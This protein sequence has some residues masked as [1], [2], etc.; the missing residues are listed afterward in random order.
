[1]GIPLGEYHADDPDAL[2][3]S[4][5][6]SAGEIFEL[7][8]DSYTAWIGGLTPHTA[9]QLR[10]WC[11]SHDVSGGADLIGELVRSGLLTELPGSGD[12]PTAWLGAY[13]I[14][15]QGAGIGNSTES[16]A[17]YT[18]VDPAGQPLLAVDAGLY[19]VWAMSASAASLTEAM[20]AVKTLTSL[21]P[22]ELWP[23]I[24]EGLP[25]LLA[26]RAA[27]LDRS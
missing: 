2:G 12:Q 7:S 17:R 18:I 1:V 10:D 20:V 21:T 13:R 24:R 3:G 16:P 4:L 11:E 19:H 22:D 27:Y 26:Y 5:V 6:C 15:P 14:H 25:Y 23:A 9:D 8:A